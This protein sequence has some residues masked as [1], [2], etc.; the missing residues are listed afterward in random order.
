M[1]KWKR[2]IG[3]SLDAITKAEAELPFALSSSYK[4]WMLRNNGKPLGDI[5]MFPIFDER[6]P[7][8]T[9]DSIVRQY[10]NGNWFEAGVATSGVYFHVILLALLMGLW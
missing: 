4:K 6:D 1:S 3:T 5:Q 7:R 2:C 8:K 10:D 9:W